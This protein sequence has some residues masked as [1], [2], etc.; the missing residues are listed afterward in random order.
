MN[1]GKRDEHVYS[2]VDYYSD[3]KIGFLPPERDVDVLRRWEITR[4]QQMSGKK[5]QTSR[6]S[7]YCWN[8]TSAMKF[9]CTSSAAIPFI[10]SLIFDPPRF[11]RT[12]ISAGAL[13][14]RIMKR[15]SRHACAF[16]E[17][18]YIRA[19]VI[20]RNANTTTGSRPRHGILSRRMDFAC[21]NFQMKK[22][23]NI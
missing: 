4:Y 2:N 7:T 13:F 6:T 23:Q 8:D 20:A 3:R 17:D 10:I 18:K 15:F 11:E 19:A 22:K 1:F 14:H 16:Q 9:H 12:L 5:R 21:S